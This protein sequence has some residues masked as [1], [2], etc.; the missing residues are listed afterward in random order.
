MTDLNIGK[1]DSDVNVEII[2]LLSVLSVEKIYFLYATQVNSQ[3]NTQVR[4]WETV[5]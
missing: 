5:L 1:Y 4:K 3:D 2:I